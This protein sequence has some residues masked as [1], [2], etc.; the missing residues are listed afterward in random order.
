MTRIHRDSIGYLLIIAFCVVMLSWGI[1]TYTPA[2]PGYGASAALVPNVAVCVVLVM[3]LV[4]LARV[5]IAIWLDKPIPLVER[6]FPGELGDSDGFTQVGRVNL[7]H[8][9]SIIGPSV[10]LLVAIEYLGYEISSIL[11]LMLIQFVIGSRRWL[12]MSVI[13]VVLTAVLFVVMRYGFGVPVPGPQY[14]L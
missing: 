6:E 1:P 13:A 5:W 11:F 10:L 9:V 7:V 8:I 4:S 12:Q 3:A 2:Y 14:F